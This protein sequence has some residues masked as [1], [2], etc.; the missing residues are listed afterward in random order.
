MANERASS[1]GSR[2]VGGV[3]EDMIDLDQLKESGYSR[4]DKKKDDHFLGIFTEISGLSTGA[5]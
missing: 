1:S 3:S 4:F 5:K 2:R